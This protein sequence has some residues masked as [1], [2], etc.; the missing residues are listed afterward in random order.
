MKGW[1]GGELLNDRAV[2]CLGQMRTVVE[3]EM[4]HL[5]AR[6]NT[7]TRSCRHHALDWPW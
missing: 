7:R 4:E 3:M 6:G 2:G 1:R 5:R